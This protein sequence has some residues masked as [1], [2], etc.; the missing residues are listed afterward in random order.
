MQPLRGPARKAR[1]RMRRKLA[2]ALALAVGSSVD[3]AAVGMS[4]SPSAPPCSAA[5]L[6][7]LDRCYANCS[8]EGERKE[9]NPCYV[10]FTIPESMDGP[11]YVYYRLTGYYA[12]HKQYVRS[13]DDAQLVRRASRRRPGSARRVLSGSPPATPGVGT[14]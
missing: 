1:T 2:L 10:N 14:P 11:V 5:S 3:N 13:R 7:A 9:H 12:N 4:L 8:G 6:R